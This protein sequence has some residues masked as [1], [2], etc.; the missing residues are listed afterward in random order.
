MRPA[1][2]PTPPSP[3]DSGTPYVP[4]PLRNVLMI[5]IDTT[6]R[7]HV[8]RYATDGEVRTPFLASL[9]ATGVAFDDHQQCSDWTYGS[10]TCTLEGRLNED[11]GWLADLNADRTPIPLGRRTLAARLG[12]L[13]WHSML[14]SSNDWLSDSWNNAQGYDQFQRESTDDTAA[15]LASGRSALE[16]AA[17]AGADPW[18]LHVHLVQAHGPYTPPDPYDDPVEA[19]PELPWSLDSLFGAYTAAEQWPD[20]TPAEQELLGRHLEARYTGEL[21]YQDDRMAEWFAEMDRD[22][23][24]DH[25]LV[26]VWTDHGEQWFERGQFGHAYDLGAEETDGVLGLW[27]KGMEPAAWDGP[28]HAVDLVP[29]VLE[30]LDLPWADE[31]LHGYPVGAA[32]PD[33]PRFSS[34]A[35]R[36]GVQASVVLDGWK[37]WFAFTGQVRLFDRAAD[38]AESI[39]RFDP[40]DPRAL[41]L[42]DLLLP[43]VAL[44]SALEA[45]DPVVWPDGLPH[46]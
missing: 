20:M 32:P 31:D 34:T 10:T 41:A 35:A 27:A 9:L 40:T 13:G 17:A 18:L 38:P 24:L 7:D 3:R 5:S 22:G 11:T 42:W 26:V 21:R 43:R 23:W 33:R 44:L 6:R 15:L 16:A 39:D 30:A 4:G 2:S 14:V 1:P 8:D 46:P 12:E 28:T 45:D 37:L 19:L 25:T 29:S 36:R